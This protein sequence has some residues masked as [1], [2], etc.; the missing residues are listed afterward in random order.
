[1]TLPKTIFETEVNKK[2]GLTGFLSLDL[3]H[4]NLCVITNNNLWTKPLSLD[5]EIKEYAAKNVGEDYSI[6]S[7]N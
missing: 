1:M 7:G 6:S 2:K 3:N 5:K 4:D